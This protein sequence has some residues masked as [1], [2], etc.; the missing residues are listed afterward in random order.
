MTVAERLQEIDRKAQTGEYLAVDVI[1]ETLKVA[2]E[3]AG[4]K[5]A[6]NYSAFHDG[7]EAGIKIKQ[8]ILAEAEA[9]KG[10]KERG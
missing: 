8:A 7:D 6:A 4:D 1:C 10:E 3:I 5:K 9:L 2:A